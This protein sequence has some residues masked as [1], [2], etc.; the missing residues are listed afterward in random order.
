MSPLA[1]LRRQAALT[2]RF[3]PCQRRISAHDIL[4]TSHVAR[5]L[6]KDFMKALSFTSIRV[7]FNTI[8]R[9]RRAIFSFPRDSRRRAFSSDK[10][11]RHRYWKFILICCA[12]R[13]DI[14]VAALFHNISDEYARRVGRIALPAGAKRYALI[15]LPANAVA[16]L[17]RRPAAP[18]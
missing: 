14:N 1:K 4:A 9:Q 18:L 8:C 10:E 11:S 7:E 15:G 5:R 12:A 17:I 2:R 3:I 16:V 6:I 13:H